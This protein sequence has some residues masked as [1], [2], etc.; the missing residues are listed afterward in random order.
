[1]VSLTQLDNNYSVFPIY[2]RI[3]DG[4]KI[5]LRIPNWYF[6]TTLSHVYCTWSMNNIGSHNCINILVFVH[7]CSPVSLKLSIEIFK[8]HLSHT[9]Q[10]IWKW[11]FTEEQTLWPNS[12][13]FLYPNKRNKTLVIFYGPLKM[14]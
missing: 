2:L 5:R 4:R 14:Q 1:M 13:I 12:L 8:I 3:Y 7:Y 11:I 9:F 6:N 10:I